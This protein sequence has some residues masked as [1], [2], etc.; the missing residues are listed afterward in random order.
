MVMNPAPI[1]PKTSPLH[2]GSLL[3]RSFYYVPPPG[4]DPLTASEADLE[5]YG[6]VPRPDPVTE[7]VSFGNWLR[8]F[9]PPI[10]FVEPQ[11]TERRALFRLNPRAT[12][13]ALTRG[14]GASRFEASRNWSGA[15]IVPTDDTMVVLVAGRWAIPALTL[16]P[17][18]YQQAGATQY[19][20]STWVGLDGQRR[21]PNSSLPQAGTMQFLTL[22]SSAPPQTSALAFFQWWDQETGGT[23]LQLR[24]LHVHPGDEMISA[25]WAKTETRAIAYLRNVTTRKM[26]IVGATSPIVKL[27]SGPPV[28]LTISGAT[29]EWILE[30]PTDPGTG[31]PYA[32]PA[33]SATTFACWAG[34]APAGGAGRPKSWH[35]LLTARFI[36]M[37]DTLHNPT[38]TVFISMPDREGDTSVRLDY[39]DFKD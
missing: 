31:A 36:R 18:A 2:Q 39:G 29:A 16:P 26:A 19:V 8:I 6:I 24:G 22:S 12:S 32:F 35:D 27:G 21:Y 15:Y 14:G 13:A 7:Q 28:G 3:A 37:Y 5:T 23:F 34:A 20:C 33:Y 4:F 1:P 11:M 10:E 38:R 17:P 25:V 30:R 9:A